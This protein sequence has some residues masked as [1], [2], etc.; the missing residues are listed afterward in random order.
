MYQNDP[1]PYLCRDS[2][3]L[4]EKPCTVFH[5]PEGGATRPII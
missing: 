2:R 3:R 4:Y 5:I 1:M